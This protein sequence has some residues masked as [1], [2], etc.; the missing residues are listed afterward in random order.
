VIIESFLETMSAANW[1]EEYLK[2][3]A[4][5]LAAVFIAFPVLCS[6]VRGQSTMPRPGGTETGFAVFQQ[7]CMSCH[8]NPNVERA[9]SP[10]A[11]REMPPEKIY[12]ALTSGVM[13]AQGEALTDFE[14]RMLALFMSGRPLGSM[15]QGDAKNMPNRCSGNPPLP[16]PAGRPAWNG[17][18]VDAAN[19]RF[20]SAAAAGITADQVP[21][22]KLKWAFGYPTG[23]SA[24]GQPTVV[25]GRVFVGTD[26]GYIYSLDAGTGCVYWSFQSKGSVRNAIIIGPSKGRT[27]AYFGDAHAN[28]YALDAQNGELLWTKKV[29]DHFTARITAAPAF[30]NGRLYVPVSS[31]EEFA[32]STLDYPCCTFRGSIVALDAGSGAQIWKTYTIAERPKPTKRNSKGVQLYAPAGASVW[33]SPTVDEARRAIYF[34]TG[35]AETEPAPN[36][37]DAIMALDMDSGKV[38]WVYQ[39][40]KNDAF[41]GGCSGTA[42]TEN[43]PSEN[44]PDLD[45]GNSPILKTLPNGRRVLVAGTKDG[46]VFAVD[47]DRKG[48]LLW[49]TSVVD[50]TGTRGFAPGRPSGIV[51]GGAADDQNV[52]YGLSGGGIA[53]VKLENGERVW[54]IKFDTGGARVSNAA[55][56]SAIPG[57]VFVGGTDG[58]LHAV[59]SGDGRPVWEF[60][61]DR[62]FETVNRV[63]ARGGAMGAPG[64]TIAGGMLFVGAG[65]GVLGGGHPGNVLLAFAPE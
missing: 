29:D 26:I 24:F 57:V 40:Q 18:G 6:P 65:Y 46:D 32:G 58:K 39:V 7:R 53:A 16:N 56:A 54:T 45:I 37:S 52:Y 59:S 63:P 14:K 50:K 9:P 43:C 28:V 2:R 41:M 19:T 23:V 55:A 27:A 11:I 36:T 49:R 10:A 44:G 35:D 62:K 61:A 4:Q 1:G 22:L 47:P 48:E 12:D 30:H 51:W 34:G 8:G 64:P 42:R 33:D 60:D 25:S 3:S 15:A 21:K 38:L 5:A 20:Q 17:W 13:K 31:S